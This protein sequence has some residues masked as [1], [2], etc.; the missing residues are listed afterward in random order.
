MMRAKPELP[1]QPDDTVNPVDKRQQILDA[2]T[3]VFLQ[4]GYGETSMERVAQESASA[5]RTLYNQ[6]KSKEALFEAMTERIWSSFP[7]FDITRDEV[8]LSDPRAA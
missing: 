4:R 8:T 6:F 7:V 1:G 3:R 2:A 5:R